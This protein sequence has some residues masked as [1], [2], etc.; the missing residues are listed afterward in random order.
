M[1]SIDIGAANAAKTVA[2][3]LKRDEIKIDLE[4]LGPEH[5]DNI[6]TEKQFAILP[7]PLF[8]QYS[9]L[10][11]KCYMGLFPE[12]HR[13]WVT[14]DNKFYSWS[15]LDGSDFNL[16]DELDQVINCAG[17]VVPK[18][19]VFKEYVKYLLVLATPAELILVAVTFNGQGSMEMNLLPTNYSAPSGNVQILQI[20]GTDTGRI[21][22]TGR[23]GCLYELTYEA[24]DGWF[25]Q[26]CRKLNHSQSHIKTLIPNFFKLA[27]DQPIISLE[28]DSSR[29]LLYTLSENS[30]IEVYSLGRDGNSTDKLDTYNTLNRDLLQRFSRQFQQPQQVNLVG[31]KPVRSNESRN[32]SLVAFS[33]KGD[34]FFFSFPNPLTTTQVYY[35]DMNVQTNA[36]GSHARRLELRFARSLQ[37]APAIAT[38]VSPQR[39]HALNVELPQC[40]EIHEVFYSHGVFIAADTRTDDTDTLFTFNSEQR[41]ISTRHPSPAVSLQ[42]SNQTFLSETIGALNIRGRTYAIAEIPL[43]V[44]PKILSNTFNNE[45]LT[46][47]VRPR[48]EFVCLSNN[49]IHLITKL[50]PIDRLLK[51]LNSAED[52]DLNI[53]R[54]FDIYG[55]DESCAMCVMLLCQSPFSE[56]TYQPLPTSSQPVIPAQ[57]SRL[58]L[59]TTTTSATPSHHRIATSEPRDLQIARIAEELLIRRG[60]EPKFDHSSMSRSN[61]LTTVGT[62]S[63]GYLYENTSSPLSRDVQ[64]SYFHNGLYLYF[65][66]VIRPMWNHPLVDFVITVDPESRQSI[67]NISNTRFN[68]QEVQLV[69]DK[70][71]ALRNF[72]ARHAHMYTLPGYH[73]QQQPTKN[74][75]INQKLFGPS[76]LFKLKPDLEAQRLQQESLGNLFLLIDRSIQVLVFVETLCKNNLLQ[77]LPINIP[78][79]QVKSYCQS[80]FKDYCVEE[81]GAY[82][83]KTMIKMIISNNPNDNTMDAVTNTLQ[84]CETFF[85]VFDLEEF[86]AHDQLMRALHCSS[87]IEQEQYLEKA[88][89]TYTEISDK[90]LN[91]SAITTKFEQLGAYDKAVQLALSAAQKIDPNHQAL[92][93]Q[94]RAQQ[95]VDNNQQDVTNHVHHAN[96]YVQQSQR[97]YDLRMECYQAA[98]KVLQ[99]LTPVRPET[100]NARN[101]VLK[102]MMLSQDLMFHESLYD[103][104]VKH[105]LVDELLK[106]DPFHLESY[107][108]K[109]NQDLNILYKYYA[110]NDHRDSIKRDDQHAAQVKLKLAH[111]PDQNLDERITH[112]GLAIGHARRAKD[113]VL[114]DKVKQDLDVAMVQK[115]VM[116]ELISTTCHQQVAD[117]AAQND[118]RSLNNDLLTLSDLYNGIAIKYNLY[119]SQL[120]ILYCA[121]HRD[122]SLIRDTFYRMVH[123]Y[124]PG[125]RCTP[126]QLES[127]SKQLEN[128]MIHSC[129]KMNN[130][131]FFSIDYVL[132]LL[133]D[134]NT[135]VKSFLN[136]PDRIRGQMHGADGNANLHIKDQMPIDVLEKCKLGLDSIYQ[137]YCSLFTKTF[138]DRQNESLRRANVSDVSALE[139]V[140]PRDQDGMLRVL[141]NTVL[142]LKNL[143][144][145]VKSS[146][147]SFADRQSFVPKVDRFMKNVAEYES[148]LNEFTQDTSKVRLMCLNIR[149]MLMSLLDKRY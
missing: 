22:L 144:E 88:L 33:N 133:E 139:N 23:D 112:L 85:G 25:R 71:L 92:E 75:P 68:S 84:K 142:S 26:K 130:S 13:A 138:K 44:E 104:F 34:R 37:Q 15:Y 14:I 125:P 7:E 89:K 97:L 5:N 24:E 50:R 30:I 137:G 35:S 82:E 72:F 27:T 107:L 55:P 109:I 61:L 57:G 42:N 12:I 122:E 49:G 124:A 102:M 10:E 59:S 64:Y 113:D 83:M 147:A 9:K 66:R 17:L 101:K 47:H 39:T 132:A 1:P 91:I 2:S 46:Q 69:Q 105:H 20:R 118:I 110:R 123:Q 60:G 63:P 58:N 106:L 53:D 40:K 131:I 73:S 128:N 4:L 87:G 119:Q 114:L 80:T 141:Y 56:I 93:Y 136:H 96:H 3:Y 52:V 117:E 38:R 143:I 149:E 41:S 120:D 70:L 32:I 36:A 148:T 77:M 48:R 103:W 74:E 16:Y 140:L 145:W 43:Y 90:V 6:F 94:K 54:F 99:D 76:G 95:Q 129:S 146:N 108:T 86:K 21:F 79:D 135:L 98:I 31:I 121:D 127:L 51:I 18:P 115:D 11:Y 45:L 62:T 81:K 65:A 8:E 29:N 78:Q 19:G 116:T 111:M 28:V 100:Q 134:Y 67:Y 126:I